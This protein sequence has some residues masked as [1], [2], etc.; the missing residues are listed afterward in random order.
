[1]TETQ[2][3]IRFKHL[4]IALALIAA[5]LII[6]PWVFAP[7]PKSFT[8]HFPSNEGISKGTDVIVAGIVVGEVK[9]VNLSPTGKGVD[10]VV[11]LQRKHENAV[12]APPQTRAVLRKKGMILPRTRIEILNEGLTPIANGESIDGENDE[13]Q[14][15]IIRAGEATR[16]AAE[17]AAKELKRLQES[18]NFNQDEWKAAMS[19]ARE[20][21]A[22]ALAEA[23]SFASSSAGRMRE[24]ADSEDGKRYRG[25]LKDLVATLDDT[26]SATM[27]DVGGAAE[28][29]GKDFKNL[30]GE[31]G[32]LDRGRTA[33][34]LDTALTEI[35]RA[36]A[37]LQKLGQHIAVDVVRGPGEKEGTTKTLEI[38]T[39]PAELPAEAEA[40]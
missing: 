28:R 5:A 1:M 37:A 18:P 10:A 40:P 25:M 39:E 29:L 15:A 20:A 11:E 4:A 31:I 38:E 6:L 34:H 30:A 9:A 23:E 26:S 14:V 13:I 17:L 12:F 8:I 21:A 2:T 7:K 22:G 24:F 27:Q 19:K 16:E 3:G 33:A 35:H 36:T 32:G